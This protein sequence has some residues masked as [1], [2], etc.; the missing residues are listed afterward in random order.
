MQSHAK[1]SSSS[2]SGH[3]LLLHAHALTPSQAAARARRPCLPGRSRSL[4]RPRTKT[5]EPPPLRELLLES[6]RGLGA[7]GEAAAAA[8]GA[9]R[10]PSCCCRRGGLGCGGIWRGPPAAAAAAPPKRSTWRSGG[11]L[12]SS[13]EPWSWAG[14]AEPERWAARWEALREASAKRPL[15]PSLAITARPGS[16]G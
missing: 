6:I 8:A 12:P 3:A 2:T 15:S 5:G 4:P 7:A 14:G 1:Q 16:L 13:A 10:P 11:A 9:A